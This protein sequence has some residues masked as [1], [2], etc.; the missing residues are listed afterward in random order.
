[1]KIDLLGWES[2]GLRC[3]DMKVDLTEDGEPVQVALIQMPNGTGKT[4]TLE[5]LKATLTGVAAGWRPDDIRELRRASDARARGRFRVDLRADSKPVTFELILDFEEGKAQYRTTSPTTG[6]LLLRW[7]PP[8]GVRRFLTPEFIRLFVFD[9]EFA[10]QLLN[11]EGNEAERAID[12]LCQL[13]LLD[14]VVHFAEQHWEQAVRG[15]GPASSTG[16]TMAINRLGVITGQIA[17]VTA[18]QTAARTELEQAT[19]KLDALDARIKA[20]IASETGLRDQHEQALI[21]NAASQSKLE[22]Q[23]IETMRQIRYPK[24]A[25]SCVWAGAS[26][27]P[28]EP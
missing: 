27:P 22:A 9:G 14:E 18:A 16:R 7:E 17:K 25:S 20:H 21:E 23:M 13:Y 2:E 15:G 12:A 28:A 4:T 3:P 1:M 19:R 26:R 10:E 8:P 24:C 6:G 11:R 5:M